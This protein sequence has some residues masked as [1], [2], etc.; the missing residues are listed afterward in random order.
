MGICTC[1]KQD[2][3]RRAEANRWEFLPPGAESAVVRR[4]KT[5]SKGVVVAYSDQPRAFNAKARLWLG[6]LAEKMST[7]D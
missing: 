5:G 4:A 7:S 6:A 1:R 3:V 2:G